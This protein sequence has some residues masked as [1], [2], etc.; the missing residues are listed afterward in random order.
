MFGYNLLWV[1]LKVRQGGA[2]SKVIALGTEATNHPNG[3]IRKIGMRTKLLAAVYVG[4]MHF[5][6]RNR[7]R[8]QG[9]AQGDTGVG[10]G[11]GVDQYNL[12]T[13]MASIVYAIYQ[14]VFGITLQGEQVVALSDA[15]LGELSINIVERSIAVDLGFTATE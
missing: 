8:Q 7:H 1:C 11:G 12:D 9:I 6:K 13:F 5:N 14:F 15:T 2:E 4:K 10:K 3:N